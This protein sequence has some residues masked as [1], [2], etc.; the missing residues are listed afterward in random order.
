MQ[1]ESSRKP[2]CRRG[3]RN[4][5]F[6]NVDARADLDQRHRLRMIAQVVRHQQRLQRFGQPRQMLDHIDQRDRE[7]AR[8]MQHG[9]SE[10]AGEH[11]VAGRDAAPRCHSAIAQAS[12]PMV[13][14]TVTSACMM[15]SRSR[16][17]RLRWRAV[18][19]R[20]MVRSKRRCSRPSP[21]K[22]LHQRH[23]ADDVDHLAVDGRGLVGEVVMQRPAGARHAKH[24]DDHDPADDRKRQPPSARS[25]RLTN[26]IATTTAAQ[27]GSTFQMNMVST[28]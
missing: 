11:H 22:A 8:R 14:A 25:P 16:Y 10:R 21:Q 1:V 9:E 28:V 19:S 6:S 26:A 20:S 27:G 24:R 2:G 4:E 5:T 18:I 15:R 12:R 17:Q 13:S 7:I 23:V 3:W